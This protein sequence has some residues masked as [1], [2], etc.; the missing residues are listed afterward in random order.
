L[1]KLKASYETLVK[2]SF[3]TCE[4]EEFTKSVAQESRDQLNNILIN[5]YSTDTMLNKSTE[6]VSLN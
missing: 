1:K 6:N 5:K 3:L 2:F 4:D